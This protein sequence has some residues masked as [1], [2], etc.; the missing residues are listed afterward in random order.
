M[1][2]YK[3]KVDEA[4]MLE[5]K[6]FYSANFLTNEKNPYEVFFLT[7][8]DNVQ[9]HC[10]SSKKQVYT[11]V[12]FGENEQATKAEAEIF[13]KQPQPIVQSNYASKGYW[14][15][16]FEQIGSDEVGIGDFFLGFFICAT[17]L[18]PEDVNY[19]TNLGIRDSK[20]LS[21]SKI[22]QLGEE[23]INTIKKSVVY[24]SPKM[25]KECY[26]KKMNSHVI[27]AKAHYLAQK[28]LIDKYKIKDNVPIYIDE[29]A[30]EE[31]YLKYVH[32]TVKNPMIFK[33]KG[34]SYYPSIATASV[35]ARYVFLKEWEKMEE[36]FDT[37]IPKG[38]SSEVDKVYAKLKKKYPQE[39]LDQYVK[40]FFRNYEN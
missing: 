4:K 9:V 27:M 1:I 17:Y 21:D 40:S 26:E 33:T 2:Y 32:P 16:S 13:F 25:I 14:E 24:I 8:K 28:Q 31:T 19:V 20:A 5:I 37:L 18:K 35:I 22:I 39:E 7:T 6:D 15:D 34:E 36:H 38:A 12:F 29:F 30:K 10:Y 11:I 3:F 23:L